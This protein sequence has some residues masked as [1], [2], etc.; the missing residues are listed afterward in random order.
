ML[1]SGANDLV[2]DER[3]IKRN[4]MEGEILNGKQ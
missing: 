1:M 3:E 4:L 2:T